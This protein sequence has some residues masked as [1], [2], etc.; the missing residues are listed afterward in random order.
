M[1]QKHGYKKKTTLSPALYT[2]MCVS[3][4]IHTQIKSKLQLGNINSSEPPVSTLQQERFILACFFL[5]LLK[6]TLTVEV[7]FKMCA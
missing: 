6:Y 7:F 2:R 3:T 4:H 1:Y 5:C